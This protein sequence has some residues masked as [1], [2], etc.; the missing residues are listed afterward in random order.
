[1]SSVRIP[2]VTSEAIKHRLEEAESTEVMINSARERYRPVATQG[3]V[4]YFV[5]ASLSEID[6]MYQ[7]SLKYFKQVNTQALFYEPQNT[8]LLLYLSS[9]SPTSALQLHHWDVREEQRARRAPPDL[10][11]PDPPQLLQQR[12]PWSVWAAQANLQ[13]HVV[14]GGHEAAGQNLWCWVAV[15]PKGSCLFGK[16][17]VGK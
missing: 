2:Q 5:I 16:G 17:E 12:V 7:F 9:L 4:L 3:S 1:M 8:L 14:C 15:L 11:A 13:P 10:A 6:P